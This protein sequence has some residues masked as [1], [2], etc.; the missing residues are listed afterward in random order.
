MG[1]FLSMK[2][3]SEVAPGLLVI[4]IQIQ[5]CSVYRTVGNPNRKGGIYEIFKL[6]RNR[7]VQI[8][9]EQKNSNRT[10]IEKSKQKGDNNSK[11]KS[12]K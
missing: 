12:P 7:K 11:Q 4:Q 2:L 3:L 8:E 1:V 6:K 10:G 9:K 5:A